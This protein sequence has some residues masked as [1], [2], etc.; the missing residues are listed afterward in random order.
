MEV[1]LTEM[2]F[3]QTSEQILWVYGIVGLFEDNRECIFADWVTSHNI[4][5]VQLASQQCGARS[6]IWDSQINC[7]T[8]L[9]FAI[10]NQLS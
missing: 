2:L 9:F 10:Y 3:V 5:G 8:E 6:Y 1:N 4:S 7:V